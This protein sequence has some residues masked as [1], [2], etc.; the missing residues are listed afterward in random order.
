MSFKIKGLDKLEKR[1]KEME[2][3]A[4]E[5]ADKEQIPFSDLFTD[6]FMAKYTNFSTFE[7][8]LSE[9]G[10]TVNSQ[11]DF[12]SIPEDEL[13]IHISKTTA[14]SSWKDMLEKATTDYCS[15][16]LGF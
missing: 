3:G 12:E 1:L 14:F 8:L 16:K 10:F 11:S 6:S 7:E 9:G 5:L 4:R 13:D 15:K 2:K